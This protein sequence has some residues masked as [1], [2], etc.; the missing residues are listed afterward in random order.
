MPASFIDQITDDM[1]AEQLAKTSYVEIQWD[2]DVPANSE[3]YEKL[4]REQLSRVMV[5]DV[6]RVLEDFTIDGSTAAEEIQAAID[7]ACEPD[8]LPENACAV[9]QFHED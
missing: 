6:R 3:D 7:L 8:D 1:I 5:T 4:V 9:V 2:G